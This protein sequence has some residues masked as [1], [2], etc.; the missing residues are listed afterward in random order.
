MVIFRI[1]RA[2]FLCVLVALVDEGG[3]RGE[4][5][6]Q[7]GTGKGKGLAYSRNLIHL[8]ALHLHFIVRQLR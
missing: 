4:G 1:D 2:L 7:S 3:G 6:E 8:P 5:A